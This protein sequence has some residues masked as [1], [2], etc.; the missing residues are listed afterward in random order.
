LS[1]EDD[2]YINDDP[3]V[4][5]YKILSVEDILCLVFQEEVD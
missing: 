5:Q 2:G 4:L 1:Q 3:V